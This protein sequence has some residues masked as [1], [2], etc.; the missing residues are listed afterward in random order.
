MSFAGRSLAAAALFTTTACF[1]QG[2][3]NGPA[4]LKIQADH[5]L[6]SVSP[7]LYGMMTEEINYS[8]DG[9]LYPEMVKNRTM[10]DPAWSMQDWLVVQNA[11]AGAKFEKDTSTG[12][13]EALTDSIKLE[14]ASASAAEPAG[15]RNMGYWGYPLKPNTTYKFSVW[16]KA[17]GGSPLHVNL[18]NNKTGK[19]VAGAEINDI[20][21]EWKQYSA[22]LHTG[23]I[24]ASEANHLELT[25]TKPGTVWLD[26]VSV[27][28]PTYHNRPNGTRIDL[29]EKLAGLHPAFL[30]FPGGNY[31]EGDHINERFE[32]KKTVGRTVDRP[33]HPSPWN[34]HSSDGMGLLEFLEWCEDL[35]MKPVL[36]V[37][38]GYSMKQEHVEPGKDLEPYVEDALEELEYVTGDASTKWGAQRIKDG[39]PEPFK[40]E[41]VEVGNEDWFD[42]SGSYD[43]R[44]KQFYEAIKAKYPSVQIIA[45]APIKSM[46][47][48]I[49]DDHFYLS[50]EKYFDDIH[51]Y[52]KFDRNGPKIF[53]GEYATM[54]G[55]PTADFG[56]ALGDAAW[57]TG[58]ERNTDVV[59]MSSYAP[60]LVNVH[61]GGM[62]WH[63]DLI[64]YDGLSS[65]GSPSYYVLSLF[66]GNIGNVVPESSIS[67]VGPRVA[68]SVTKKDAD[69][70]IYL[71][72]VNGVPTAQELEIDL[73]GVGAITGPIKVK[74][75]HALSP[76]DTNTITDP[77][78]I[79][80]VESTIAATGTKIKHSLG[81][82][83]FEVLEIH[84]KK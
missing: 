69:G 46:K 22:E 60:L 38:G 5:T 45:T 80:P 13:S 53:M 61:N 1:A 74:R 63:P 68:Y 52:D 50:A 58:V 18:V 31:L 70:T 6:Y 35:K 84:T 33:T 26:V 56:A 19:S 43:G 7:M 3:A 72:I 27:F 29:M 83:T 66:A 12:P 78:H 62:Q 34:Y 30:R 28:P 65:Y 64:G 67:G 39:H 15:I 82:Y 77:K 8:Y 81:G 17:E 41:Y 36:A 20:S 55:S 44:Y 49:L 57:L 10:R 48:D 32:W 24:E 75:L 40:L 54:E 47:P 4:V 25:L 79:V 76:A 21:G 11:A 16:A 73:A 14:V 23:A 37:Y 42:K 9:G 2:A 51:H 71:K 59:V